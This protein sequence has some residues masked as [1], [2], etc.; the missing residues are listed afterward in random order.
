MDDLVGRELL[1][2][3]GLDWKYNTKN[4]SKGKDEQVW[5]GL[6]ELRLGPKEIFCGN[7]FATCGF[8]E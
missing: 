3:L 6:M 4:W 1:Q 8:Y 7:V 2:N 5:I